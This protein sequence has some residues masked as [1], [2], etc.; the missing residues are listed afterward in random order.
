MTKKILMLHG[1][2]QSGPYFQSKTKG[3]A[4]ALEAN[5]YE[6][7]YP[8]A[9]NK[10][11]SAN[12]PD[13]LGDIDTSSSTNY[14]AWIVPGSSDEEYIVPETSIK[15]LRDYIVEHGPFYGFVGFSQGGGVTGF[16]MTDFHGLLGISEE[17]HPLPKFFMVFAGFRL[18]PERYQAQYDDNMIKIPSLHVQGEL[19]TITELEKVQALYE[20]CTEDSR[21]FLKHSGAHFVPNSRGFM[22]K[23]SAWMENIDV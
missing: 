4:K 11:S 3:F 10:L 21:T 16:L 7:Y 2:A 22:S 5:G 8:T 13:A 1:L 14:N 12:L 18:R 15:F 6:L 9:P 19:D 17:E 20:S 23:V